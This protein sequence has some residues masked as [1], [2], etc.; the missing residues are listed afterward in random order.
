MKLTFGGCSFLLV[1]TLIIEMLDA[2]SSS[3]IYTYGR[4]EGGLRISAFL[5][6]DDLCSLDFKKSVEP[7]SKTLLL[8][9][10]LFCRGSWPF[11]GVF[12]MSKASF[13][14]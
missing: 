13:I 7:E 12:R 11:V 9:K 2:S 1:V 10:K 3:S 14:R 8:R 4:P 5:L 6:L